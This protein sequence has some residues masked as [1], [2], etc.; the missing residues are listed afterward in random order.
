MLVTDHAIRRY[1][2]R[3]GKKTASKRRIFSQINRDLEKDVRYRKQSKVDNHYILV[4]SKYKA[5]CY[6]SRVITILSLTQDD[7][8]FKTKEM[9]K[10]A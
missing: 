10:S 1:K 9:I 7:T 8:S 6:R 4:T 5:V 3:V 2:K